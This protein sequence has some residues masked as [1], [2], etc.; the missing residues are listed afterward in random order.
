[1]TRAVI[2]EVLIF[3]VPFALFALFLLARKRNPLQGASWSGNVSWLT[4]AGL[5]LAIAGLVYMGATS[6]RRQGPFVP[7]HLE[8][9]RVVP[10]QFQ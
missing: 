3:L 1:M 7:T 2:T 6:E 5:A 10:G 4:L 9:G 8:N